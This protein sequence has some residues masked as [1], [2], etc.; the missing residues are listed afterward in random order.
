[1]EKQR[2]QN[3][4]FGKP[5]FRDA[6]IQE[7]HTISITEQEAFVSAI[8]GNRLILFSQIWDI[9]PASTIPSNVLKIPKDTNPT[10]AAGRLEKNSSETHE[11]L[12]C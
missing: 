6:A 5:F 4:K 7:T 12:A 11:E 8:A 3:T 1:M 10:I 9:V 2:P